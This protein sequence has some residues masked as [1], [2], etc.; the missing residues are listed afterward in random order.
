[1]RIVLAIK[2]F[3][4]LLFNRQFADSVRAISAGP[5]TATKAAD[6]PKVEK[7]KPAPKPSRS[8]AITLLAALQREARFVDILKEPLADYSDEQIGAAARDVLRDSAKV[9]ERF[10]EIQPLSEAEEG[11][12]V[13]TP[14]NFDP[15]HYHLVGNVSGEGPMSGQMTHHGWIARKCE[16]P[17]WNGKKASQN[18]IAPIEIQV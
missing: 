8:D 1:M 10:F 5:S 7:P 12:T 2:T 4:K 3:F 16:V 6:K 18:I 14:A 11:A 17:K 9:V 13:E 15:Q